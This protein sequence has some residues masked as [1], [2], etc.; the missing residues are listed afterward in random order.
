MRAVP[1]TLARVISMLHEVAA[2]VDEI[3]P[4]EQPMRY[5]NRAF[6]AW[7][8]RLVEKSE[9][10]LRGVLGDAFVGAEVELSPYLCEAFG[11]P[12]RIDY[13]TGHETSFVVLLCELARA[14]VPAQIRLA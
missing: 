12:T 5:G 14:S 3:K 8:S 11:N 7:H 6:R 10:L 2:W 4:I 13:G 1:Q 9:G